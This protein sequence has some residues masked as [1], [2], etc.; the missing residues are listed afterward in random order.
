MSWTEWNGRQLERKVTSLVSQANK[1]TGDAIHAEANQQ[2][3]HDEG[4]LQ[5]SG[6][7]L[8]DPSNPT[9]V[10]IGYG[11]GGASGRPEVPYA[12]KWHEAPANF[13]KGRKHNYLADPVR[14]IGPRDTK[15]NLKKMLKQL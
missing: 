13:Q 4:T 2:V 11:G 6:V 7:V 10:Y 14:Q 1:M 9:I 8:K 12:K 5:D 3:P 15:E